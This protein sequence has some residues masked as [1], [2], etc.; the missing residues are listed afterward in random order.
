MD[1]LQLINELFEQQK[2]K[3]W[4]PAAVWFKLLEKHRDDEIK[5]TRDDLVEVARRLEYSPKWVDLKLEELGEPVNPNAPTRAIFDGLL[6]I[7]KL[8]PF[9][10]KK[11][12]NMAFFD[13]KSA[14][15]FEFEGVIFP[16]GFRLYAEQLIEGELIWCVGKWDSRDSKYQLVIEK[17]FRLEQDL[18]LKLFSQVGSDLMPF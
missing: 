1:N 17:A 16:G 2:A 18:S 10:T 7:S 11:G 13:L 9:Q 14:S 6:L 12:D 15:G 3:N 4:K 8:H 5:L